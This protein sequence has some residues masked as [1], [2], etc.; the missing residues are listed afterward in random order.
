[1]CRPIYVGTS[2]QVIILSVHRETF[3]THFNVPFLQKTKMKTNQ[4]Y[5]IRIRQ[6]LLFSANKKMF[7]RLHQSIK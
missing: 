6:I 7:A 3:E 5:G 1:M 2:K 4:V